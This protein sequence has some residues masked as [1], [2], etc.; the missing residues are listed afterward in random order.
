MK[1]MSELYRISLDLE[2]RLN[3]VYIIIHRGKFP[4]RLFQTLIYIFFFVFISEIRLIQ[5]L[6]IKK[7]NKILVFLIKYFGKT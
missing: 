2:N 1:T 7:I 3:E 5:I 6:L 4:L